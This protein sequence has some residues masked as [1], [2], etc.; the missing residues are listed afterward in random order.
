MGKLSRIGLSVR[1]HALF[2]RIAQLASGSPDRTLRG[3]RPRA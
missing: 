1:A 2:A 3:R